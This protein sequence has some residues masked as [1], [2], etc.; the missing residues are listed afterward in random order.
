MRR[1]QPPLPGQSTLKEKGEKASE[2]NEGGILCN[3][4]KRHPK[5]KKFNEISL[6]K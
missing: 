2:G 4:N 1:T 6:K 3:P 5:E